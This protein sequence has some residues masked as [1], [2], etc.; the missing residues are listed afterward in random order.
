MHVTDLTR[1]AALIAG[2]KHGWQSTHVELAER[3][4]LRFCDLVRRNPDDRLVPSVDVDLVWHEHLEMEDPAN[5]APRH[6]THSTFD[7]DQ[8]F[9]LTRERY[10]DIYGPPGAIWEL[11]AECQT[12]GPDDGPHLDR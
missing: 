12:D 8:L 4:Y 7:R 5:R 11:S 1:E 6:E 9:D 3:E 2:R 10:T